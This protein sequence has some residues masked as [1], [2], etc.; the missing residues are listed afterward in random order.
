MLITVRVH[1]FPS[2]TRKLSSLVPTIL[3]WKRPGTI[4][5]RQHKY[6]SIA[7]PVEHATVN[8]RVVGS[9]PTWGAM[10]RSIR[11]TDASFLFS[12]NCAAVTDLACRS[13]PQ[14]CVESMPR[15][16]VWNAAARGCGGT[17]KPLN[18]IPILCTASILY[19]FIIGRNLSTKQTLAAARHAGRG[20][21]GQVPL[22]NAIRILTPEIPFS[23]LCWR[24]AC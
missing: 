13:F 16:R 1:P 7:Q 18:R 3:G 5:R 2:R 22:W 15:R 8:R 6:S 21:C 12:D 9:S 10:L 14:R 20:E 19:L 17:L 11:K 4:G 23:G 24:C